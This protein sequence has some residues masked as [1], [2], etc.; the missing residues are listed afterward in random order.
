MTQWRMRMLQDA[1]LVGSLVGL[2]LVV[3]EPAQAQHPDFNGDGY[4]D[5]AIGVPFE[6]VGGMSNAG[7]V[8]V[9]Y[10]SA[11]DLATNGAQFW[12]QNKTN[13]K[14]TAEAN[15]EFGFALAWGDFNADNFSDLAIGARG[16]GVAGK[17]YAGAVSVLY[18]GLGGLSAAGN[19]V[20][21][22]ETPGVIE[23]AQASDQF[24][25]AL[26]G[27][28]FD[29]DGFD[30][31][32]IGV[33]GEDDAAT[34]VVDAGAVHVLFGTP[35][36]LS[37][38][39]SEFWNQDNP[40]ILE[41]IGAGDA[42]GRA[43][44]AGD[45]DEDGF[46]DLAIGVPYEDLSIRPS[47][48]SDAGAVNVL[49]GASFGLSSNGNQLWTQNSLDVPGSAKAS[50]LFGYALAAG[51][52]D[53]DGN[54]DLAVGVPWEEVGSAVDAGAV[55]VLYG[56]GTG[57]SGADGQLLHQDSPGIPDAAQSNDQFGSALAAADFDNGHGDLAIGA[58]GEDFTFFGTI[59][60]AG[61]VNV[62][63]G[64]GTGLGTD[65]TEDQV[66][67]I[68]AAPIE[69][70][71]RFGSSLAVGDFDGNG[72]AD[73][74]AHAPRADAGDVASAGGVTVLYGSSPGLAS[75]GS[76]FWTQDTPGVPDVAE[77][78]DS[79]GFGLPSR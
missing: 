5:L 51:D 33:S 37:A 57:L 28:D 25:I 49:Y 21:T 48:I 69:Q 41:T 43:L 75:S 59:S 71:D 63:Y 16:E 20:W 30:D 54:A 38:A 76:Q 15:D 46:D 23:D 34:G 73:L 8:N 67:F 60:D 79:F 1:V 32:A 4:T 45:F 74:V 31:L 64:A 3:A 55:N 50:D 62:I 44:A 58:P 61:A 53:L 39:G 24:G 17:A 11:L 36:G 14:D 10:G 40:N 65:S 26:V 22:Q 18:G 29:G 27:G 70:G 47:T 42:F 7:A 35:S 12:H 77:Q 52:F 6:D 68:T 56:I 19:Q 9:L 13:I 2:A 72:H 66:W 78:G